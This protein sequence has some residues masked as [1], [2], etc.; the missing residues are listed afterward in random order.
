M[1]RFNKQY[2]INLVIYVDPT[3][4][5]LELENGNNEDVIL[6]LIKDLIYDLDDVD[7]KEITVECLE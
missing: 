2:E 3:A 1:P 6:D 5:F 7:I 4:A